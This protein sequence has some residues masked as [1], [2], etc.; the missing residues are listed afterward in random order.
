[1]T[2]MLAC[3]PTRS[4]LTTGGKASEVNDGE[5]GVWGQADQDTET[6]DT[7]EES[8]EQ[9]EELRGTS[10]DDIPVVERDPEVDFSTIGCILPLSGRSRLVGETVLKGVMQGAGA[11]SI[12]NGQRLIVAV[13]DSKSDPETAADAVELLVKEKRV[14]AIV[15]PMDGSAAEA[16]AEVAEDLEIP[17]LLFSIR[18]EPQKERRFA[19]R[20]FSTNR[21]EVRALVRAAKE[22]GN[23]KV[24]V[25]F[26]SSG[27]GR[28]MKGLMAEEVQAKGLEMVGAIS[29]DPKSSSFV[30]ATRELSKMDFDSLFIPDGA[31]R[32]ALVAPSLA[33]AGLWSTPIGM[34]PD[35]PGR[36]IQLLIPSAGL[37]KD[38]PR[39]A[40]RYLN[41]ALFTSYLNR[42]SSPGAADFIDRFELEHGVEP[43][44]L[45]GFGHDAVVLVAGAIRF[46]APDREGIGDWLRE[47]S[48]EEV[49]NLPL[50]MPFEGFSKEGEPLAHPWILQLL[51]DEFV[52][53]R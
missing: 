15:G 49:R 13:Q 5:N 25:L 53:L 48:T 33:S 10:S 41:G 38:L 36:G 43:S 37:S 27:Y 30:G 22:S 39:R 35:G 12:G 47:S 42:E 4:A 6:I 18:K 26:P 17:L 2:T 8:G 50:A 19:F 9:P 45:S 51:G 29:Y 11:I 32:I 34:E 14:A 24:A 23:S 40:G 46:G 16:A 31:A 20:E 21:S 7:S 1:M 3:G 52:A 28:T 44:F